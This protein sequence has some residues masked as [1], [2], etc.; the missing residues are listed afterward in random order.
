MAAEQPTNATAARPKNPDQVEPQFADLVRAGRLK[1]VSA[2]FWTPAAPTNPKPGIFYLRH[3]GFLGAEPPSVKGLKPAEF[4][5]EADTLT[6]TFSTPEDLTMLDRTADDRTAE[7]AE[8][9]AELA[10]RNQELAQREQAIAE[11][12]R[13]A[14]EQ[15]ATIHRSECKA[16]AEHIADEGR[17]LPRDI[18]PLAALLATLP[19]DAAAAAVDFA[20]PAEGGEPQARTPAAYLR[21]LL[22]R[23]PVQ[24]DYSERGQADPQAQGERPAEFAAPAGYTVDAADL[25]LHRKA[26]AYRAAH[27]DTDYLG[28]VRAVTR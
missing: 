3:L 14:A 24:V 21:D 10:K 4:A 19:S 26:L 9:E 1:Y 17:I 7:F 2:S 20:E 11:R 5:D 15:A 8:R 6:L 23:L 27:P 18:A 12:E 13:L 28:A 16:F 25:A 22:A